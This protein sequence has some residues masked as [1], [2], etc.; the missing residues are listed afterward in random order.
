[1]TKETTMTGKGRGVRPP[2][3]GFTGHFGRCPECQ[4]AV[5]VGPD[6]RCGI[7]WRKD[8][9]ERDAVVVLD[10]A[11]G[12]T[13]ALDCSMLVGGKRLLLRGGTA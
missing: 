8:F 4:R 9:M 10:D 12:E 5:R 1:M 7:C 2:F 13:A 11:L 3:V 6:G